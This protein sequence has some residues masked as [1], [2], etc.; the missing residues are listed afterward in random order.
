MISDPLFYMA[1]IPAVLIS[2]ASKGGFGTGLGVIAVPMITLTV[3]VNQAIGI[4]LP[5]LLLMDV[6]SIWVYRGKWDA[7]ILRLLLPAALIG[8]AMGTVTFHWMNEGAIRVVI[9]MVAIGFALYSWWGA[10][11]EAQPRRAPAW[12]GF[13]W[14]MLSGFT[15]FVAH[16]GGPPLS[17]YLL[18]QRLDKPVFVGTTVVFFAIV[19]ASK[20]A[21]Y[22]WLGQLNYG[23]LVTAGALSPLVPIG[24]GLGVLLNRRLSAQ[25]F[26]RICYWFIFLAGCKLLYDGVTGLAFGAG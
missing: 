9:G 20:L 13:F 18:P 17:V 12:A 4:L 2:G 19:N 5:L 11:G 14:G 25:L 23:N 8:I 24:I 1:A 3:S 15:S 10:P 22:A 16:A 21:P 26:Y 7:S 6:F